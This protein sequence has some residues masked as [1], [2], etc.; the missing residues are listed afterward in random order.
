MSL[1]VLGPKTPTTQQH[2]THTFHA[3]QSFIRRCV[4]THKTRYCFPAEVRQ[5]LMGLTPHL[6]TEHRAVLHAIRL[7]CCCEVYS[8]NQQYAIT[9]AITLLILQ[10]NITGPKRKLSSETVNLSTLA[11]HT[12]RSVIVFLSF[13]G[14]CCCLRPPSRAETDAWLRD[15]RLQRRGGDHYV[16]AADPGFVMDANTGQLVVPMAAVDSQVSPHSSVIR[17]SERGQ[18]ADFVERESRAQGVFRSQQILQASPRASNNGCVP[19]M[20]CFRARQT[21]QHSSRTDLFSCRQ[22]VLP[23]GTPV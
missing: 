19:S 8:A 21:N 9:R 13:C 1:S 23:Q 12:C 4:N 20:H 15:R 5:T 6:H 7:A 18:C 10:D 3:H 14:Y 17:T 22:L 11:E 16:T 2:A